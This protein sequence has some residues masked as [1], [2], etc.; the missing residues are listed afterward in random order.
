[1]DL[2]PPP[3]RPGHG[4]SPWSRLFRTPGTAKR[5]HLYEELATLL[6]AGIGV[7]SAVAALEVQAPAGT[8]RLVAAWQASVV[9]GAPLWEAM[10][11]QPEAFG[12][13][14]VSLVRIGE[15]SG[16]LVESLRGLSARLE[17]ERKA[18]LAALGA[19]AYPALVMHVA[20]FLP[21]IPL[22]G[23]PHGAGAYFMTVL[24]G[25]AVIWGV[26]IA[27]GAFYARW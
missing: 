13:L 9:D 22:I 4:R 10:E 16:R 23:V 5:A 11:R 25:L 14:E 1:M 3:R 12:P 8:E 20:L 18:R 17:G 26:P 21:T 15:R 7:R 24:I 2:T 19:V 27:F 6:N